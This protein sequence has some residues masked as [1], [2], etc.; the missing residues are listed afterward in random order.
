MNRLFGIFTAGAMAIAMNGITWAADDQYRSQGSQNPSAQTD[1]QAGPSNKPA[2][3]AAD[4]GN[5]PEAAKGQKEGQDAN[6]AM[7]KCDQITDVSRKYDC[8]KKAQQDKN[9]QND[10]TQGQTQEN[11]ADAGADTTQGQTQENTADAGAD[12]TQGQTQENTA[13]AADDTTQG[14][15]QENTANAGDDTTQGQA[16]ENTANT[17]DDTTQ[18]QT[19]ENTAQ[20]GD[21]TTQG[22][23]QENTANAGDDTTQGQTQEDTANAGTDATQGQTQESTANAGDDQQQE[24][25]ADSSGADQ[26]GNSEENEEYTAALKK[27]DKLEGA[28]KANCRAAAKEKA[29]QM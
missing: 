16:Q 17:G 15:T 6:A 8:V 25:T 18:S 29:G 12:T 21:D 28:D 11:T 27:C 22:Q 5:K 20:A 3:E 4:K 9:A 1:Q 19:Q 10:A 23:A 24:S 13:D 14:Q 2:N 7:K 26:A